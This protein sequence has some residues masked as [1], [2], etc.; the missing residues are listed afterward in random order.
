MHHPPLETL[1][2][3][4]SEQL[5]CQEEDLCRQILHQ[6]ARG[7]PVAPSTLQHALQIS[8]QELE[9]RL[10]KLAETEVDEQGNILGWG[11]TLVPTSHRFQLDGM[12]LYTWCAFD[13][14]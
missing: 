4:L 10:S 2:S 11:V 14:V 6:V 3:H 12:Q 9:Q 7:K 1:A 5:R 13:T 8:Q